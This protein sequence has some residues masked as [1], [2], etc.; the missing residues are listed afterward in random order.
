MTND[1]EELSLDNLGAAYARA[2]ARHDPDS[3]VVAPETGEHEPAASEKTDEPS[4]ELTD[5]ADAPPTP[6]KIVEAALFVGHPRNEPLTLERLA[7]LMRDVTTAEVREVIDRLNDSYREASQGLRI[8]AADH[9]FKM[10]IAP[11][12]ETVRRSFLGRVRE[13]RL[14]QALVEVLALVAYQP[15]ISASKVRDQRGSESAA[16]LNQLVRRRLVELRREIDSESGKQVSCYF[17]TERF[18]ML[19]DLDSL[20]DLPR[21]EEGDRSSD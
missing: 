2:A 10:T 18:L 1:E 17:P 3:F 8:V 14:S 15:G 16:L 20:E 21:V 11:E 4:A 7:S 5:Q 6:E 9:G 19:F 12:V 13:A